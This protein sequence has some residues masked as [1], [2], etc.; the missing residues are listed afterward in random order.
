MTES[1]TG[2][3]LL[4]GRSDADLGDGECLLR[5]VDEV[6]PIKGWRCRREDH[7]G[8]PCHIRWLPPRQRATS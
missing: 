1:D 6:D 7:A 3:V 4:P 5:P 8:R 2:R